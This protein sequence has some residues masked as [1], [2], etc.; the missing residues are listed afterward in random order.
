MKNR[1]LKFRAW[2]I[3]SKCWIRPSLLEVFTDNGILRNLYDSEE[4]FTIIEQFTGIHDNHGKEIYEGDILQY[5]GE[6]V[7]KSRMV[8]RWTTEDEDNHPG[9]MISD[10][11]SQRGYPTIIG[12]VHENP[13]LLE[14]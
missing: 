3:E 12:N 10:S 14:K 11:Y 8:V 9:F 13:E 2:D 4:L 5:L 7:K 6:D 1:I